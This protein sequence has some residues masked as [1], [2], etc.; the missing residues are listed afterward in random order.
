MNCVCV[1]GLGFV[2]SNV[3]N[4]LF[5]LGYDVTVVDDLSFGYHD[6]MKYSIEIVRSDFD[7]PLLDSDFW[8]K[9]DMMVFSACMNIIVAMTEPIKTF[10]VN[11][12]KAL[13]IFD[14][15]KGKIINLS[16]ASVYGNADKIPTSES[17]QIKLTNAYDSSKYIA[18]LYLRKRRDFTTLRLSNVYG[19]NQRSENPYCGVLGKMMRSA[20]DNVPMQI[21]GDG[22]ATRDY[23]HVDDVVDAVVKSI[24]IP[25]PL[26]CEVNIATGIETSVN[27]LG[28]RVWR[29]I[30]K[31]QQYIRK[32]PRKIDIISRR[33]LDISKAKELLGWEP[34]ISLD[35]GIKL[36]MDW[37]KSEKLL[38]F[39]K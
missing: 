38:T 31:P 3:A 15:F 11:S 4:K 24:E 10:E 39:A 8:D 9:F 25:F 28:A 32:E 35:E 36:T 19:A 5:E 23:T 12:V 7:S 14:R 34:K 13:K 2:G 26:N 22:N 29:A 1:G 27:D 20:I 6:N 37:M 16:T 30:N 17:A 21:Y 33:C 18:E